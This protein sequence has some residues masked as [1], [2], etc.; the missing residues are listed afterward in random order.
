MQLSALQT[1]LQDWKSFM[2]DAAEMHHN[3]NKGDP[4]W[5]RAIPMVASI[6]CMRVIV[7][8]LRSSSSTY[9]AYP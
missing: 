4:M 7:K 6:Y 3:P 1:P 9:S 5:M 2:L 8:D